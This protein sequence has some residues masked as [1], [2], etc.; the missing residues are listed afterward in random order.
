MNKGGPGTVSVLCGIHW[1]RAAIDGSFNVGICGMIR[2]VR[3]K[4]AFTNDFLKTRK[5][6]SII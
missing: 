6:R 1:D 3:R 4:A 2:F 5:H